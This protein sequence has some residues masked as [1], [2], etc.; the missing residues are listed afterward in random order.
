[1]G[2][3][4]A[5][6][7]FA[8]TTGVFVTLTAN[9]GKDLYL[10]TASITLRA[11]GAYQQGNVSLVANSVTIDQMVFSAAN[12]VNGSFKLDFDLSTIKV[13]AGETIVLN[14]TENNSLFDIRGTL[15][16]WEETTGETPQIP[17]I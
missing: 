3:Q 2:S 10:S 13:L 4:F 12:T 5:G 14:L 9:T 16:G 11:D 17:S 15:I 7:Q 8:G 6:S 1:M